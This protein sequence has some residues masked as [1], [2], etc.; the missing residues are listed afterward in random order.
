MNLRDEIIGDFNNLDNRVIKF[1]DRTIVDL[2][3]NEEITEYGKSLL[4]MLVMQLIVYYK[5]VDEV[6]KSTQLRNEDVYRTSKSPELQVLQK[7]HDQ[8]LSILDKLAISPYNKAKVKK[9]NSN[10]DGE[11]A[12]ELLA[13]I[14]G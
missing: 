9:L 13:D 12:R 2:S 6:I 4:G 5:A 3:K 7:T 1:I 8:I 10:D 14:I 11:K